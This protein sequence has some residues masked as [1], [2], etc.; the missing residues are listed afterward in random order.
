MPL[1][2]FIGCDINQ[3][4]C[5]VTVDKLNMPEANP[6]QSRL[7]QNHNKGKLRQNNC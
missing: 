4:S 3:K 6:A 5:E 7:I 1:R 2:E